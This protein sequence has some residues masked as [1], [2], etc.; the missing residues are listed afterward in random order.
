MPSFNPYEA[1][2][3]SIAQRKA[4]AQGLM[5][6]TFQPM[7]AQKA[8]RF[9]V[10]P[11][12]LEGLAK[13]L[14]AG[15][16]GKQM[17]GLEAES[18]ALGEEKNRRASADATLLAQA[19]QGR[20]AQAGGLQE[21]ASGNA[22]QGQAMPAQTP[23][24]SLGQAMPMLSPGMQPAALQAMQG[25]QV[26]QDQQ[27]FQAE[28]GAAARADRAMQAQIADQRARERAGEQRTF[29]DQQ[30]RQAALDRQGLA[31]MT[32]AGRATGEP[33]ESVIGPDG[34]PVLV[35]R[36]QAAGKRP[37]NPRSGG[38][39]LPTAALKMQNEM[40]EALGI[41]GSIN[42]DLS[43]IHNQLTG[44]QLSLGPMENRWSQARNFAGMSSPN[45]RNF[46]TFQ[47]TLE[48][49]RND[50]LR[51]NSGVQTE[52][53]AQRAW[54]E[55]FA[56]INDP[57]VV[58]QRIAEIQNINQRAAEMKKMQI[59]QLRSNFGVDPLDA[60][61]FMTPPAA[62]GGGPQRRATDPAND[63]LGIRRR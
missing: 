48:K 16:V 20:P 27:Q 23:V 10:A 14:Q 26:R 4:L 52:G 59:D 1:D 17:A 6:T 47:A 9:V 31:Q 15:V 7:Q 37:W 39:N 12:P 51:L 40:L 33:M 29:L 5:G 32:M 11:S 13:A 3:Q 36:S 25:A 44:G 38:A 46:A 42:S 58:Q 54:N 43:A 63:P 62:V 34:Q 28:Q 19:L 41:S 53:D 18:K 35:P 50:S 2:E 21:D 60:S 30:A 8:G 61:A 57:G 24:Q 45:S 55:L 22:W 49:L 56:N